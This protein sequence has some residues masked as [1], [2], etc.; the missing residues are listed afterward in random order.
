MATAHTIVAPT[1]G[2]Y[3]TEPPKDHKPRGLLVGFHGY[4][5]SADTQL[6]R[7]RSIPGS[8]DWLLVSIQG[9]HRF[10]NRRTQE[11]VAS[12]MTSQDR[13]LMIA[14]NLRFVTEVVDVAARD[15]PVAVPLVFAGFSQ[16][17]SM[18]F[19]AACNASRA[20]AGAIA[21][22]GDV[23][24]ELD[25]HALSLIPAA[26]LGRGIR[27]EW[28]SPEHWAADQARLEE[29]GVGLTVFGFDGGH[30]WSVE[31]SAAV[32]TFLQRLTSSAR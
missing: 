3:L 21:V 9:L 27:D 30:E 25:R 18:M 24:P 8:A 4:A 12:W 28:Y 19:R 29:A 10:Y 15:A 11:V 26:F 31:V 14:D 20:I 1:H 2:R 22:G 32:G 17:V 16:G 23:P 7:L 6:E 5:E 13:E